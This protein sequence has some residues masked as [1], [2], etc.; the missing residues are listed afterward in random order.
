MKGD[1]LRKILEH[2]DDLGPVQLC[3]PWIDRAKRAKERAI[4]Q[5]DR[6]RYVA[7]K[8]IHPRGMVVSELFVF[9]D[10][11]DDNS[12]ATVADFVADG[13]LDV[14]FAARKEAKSNLVA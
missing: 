4:R 1:K 8:P 13:C 11:I 12:P 3:R 5:N 10:V 2:P 7:L 6:H 9:R 14:E